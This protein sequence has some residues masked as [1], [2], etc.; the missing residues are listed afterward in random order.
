[1]VAFGRSRVTWSDGIASARR[2]Y[3]LDELDELL[4]EASLPIRWRSSRWQPR[5]VTAADVGA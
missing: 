2:S 3:T 1:V 4:G 5:I